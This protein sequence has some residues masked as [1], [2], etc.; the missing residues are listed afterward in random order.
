MRKKF[1]LIF[2]YLFINLCIQAQQTWL[3]AKDA[4]SG[5]LEAG[6]DVAV[7][8]LGNAY[9]GG[10]FRDDISAAYGSSFSTRY[11]GQD[12]FVAKYSSTG[13]LIWAFKLGS[14]GTDDVTGIAADAAGNFYITGS[15]QNVAQFKGVATSASIS[16]TSA[17]GTDAFLAKYNSLGELQW[18]KQGTNNNN[19]YAYKVSLHSSKIFVSGYF[20]GNANFSFAGSNSLTSVGGFDA[21]FSVHDLSGNCLMIKKVGGTAHDYGH[22]ITA[23]DNN[24][25]SIGT[26]FSTSVSFY[27]DNTIIDST[28]TNLSSGES[29]VFYSAYSLATGNLL[30]EERIG[31][32]SGSFDDEGLGI[33]QSGNYIYLTGGA[34]PSTI[35]PGV[36][37]ISGTIGES[38]FLSQALKSNGQ[39]LWAKIESDG[40]SSTPGHGYDI[41]IKNDKIW[42]CG[43]FYSTTNFSG[44]SIISGG[45]EDIFVASYKTDGTLRYVKRAGESGADKAYGLA[46]HGGGSVYISGLVGG[47]AVFDA[48]TFNATNGQNIGVA[49][50]GCNNGG[51]TI[52]GT[53][54][55]TSGQSA[56]LTFNFSGTSPFDYTYSDGTSNYSGSTSSSSVTVSV[57]PAATTTYSLVA[58]TSGTYCDALQSNLTGSAVI[59]VNQVINN[60]VIAANQTI[61]PGQMPSSLTGTLPSGGSGFY[62]YVWQ[63]STDS[64]SWITATGLNGL[65]N[66]SP[67]FLSNKTY[68]RRVVSAGSVTSISNVV[69]ISM[70]VISNNSIASSQSLCIGQIP[71]QLTGTF[72]SGGTGTFSYSWEQSQDNSLWLPGLGTNTSQNYSPPALSVVTYYRRIVSSGTCASNTSNIVVIT[73]PDAIAN[74]IISSNQSICSGQT[75]SLLNGTTPTGGNTAY[76]YLWQQSADSLV[77]SNASGINNLINYNPGAPAAIL[78]FRRQVS[79]GPCA[80]S[81]SNAVKINVLPLITNNNISADQTICSGQTPALLNGTLPGGGNFS[82]SYSWE[83]SADSIT[84]TAAPGSNTVQ[85]YI[86]AALTSTTY[87]KRK[88]NSGSCASESNI[89]K[90]IVLPLVSN[91]II[92]SGQTICSGQTPA[93]LNGSTPTGGNMAY[94]YLWEQSSDNVVWTSATGTNNSQN[95]SPAPLSATT[96]Y[97]RTVSSAMCSS[98]ISNTITIT[99]F[100]VI[101][102]NIVTASQIICSGQTPSVLNGSLPSGGNGSY[103]YLWEQSTDSSTWVNASGINNIQNYS[104]SSLGVTTYYRRKVSSAMCSSSISVPVTISVLPVI[105]NNLISSNQTICSGQTPAALSGSVPVGGNNAY[106]YLWEQSSDNVSWTN[107]AGVNNNQNYSPGLLSGTVYF[108]RTV[109]SAMCSSNISSVITITV[110]PVITNNT[111]SSDQTICSGQSPVILNGSAAAG[112]NSSYVY[113]WEQSADNLTWTNANA[114]NNLQNYS[115]SPLTA[116]T[117]FRRTVSSAMC[118]SNTSNAITVT[119]LPVVSNNVINAPQTICS[120]QAPSVLNGS[121]PSGGNNTYTYLWEQSTDSLLWADA[122]GINNIQ[123]YSPSSLSTTTYFRRTVSSAMCSSYISNVITITVLP[124]ITNN[125]ISSS[126][127]ICAGQIPASLNGTIPLGGNNTYTYLWEESSDNISWNVAAGINN[128]QNYSPAALTN[129]MYYRRTVSSAMCSSNTSLP[130]TIT[131]LPVITGNAISTDQTVCSGQIP[132]GLNGSLPSGGN[133]SYTYLWEQSS[134]S[135]SWINANGINNVQS[136][137]PSTLSATTYYR[138]TVSSAMCSLSISS[139]VKITVLPVIANNVVSAGQTVCFGQTP[140]ALNGSLPSGGNSSFTYLWEQSNDNISWINADGVNNTQNYSAASLSSTTYYRRKVSS[141]MCSEAISNV[142]TITVLPL[143]S[144]NIISSGQTICAGQSPAALSGTVPSGGNNSYAY[145]W[146]QSTDSIS[147]SAANVINTSQNYS[148]STLSATTYYRRIISSAMCSSDTS[149]MVTIIVLPVVTNNTISVNQTICSGQSPSTI[150]GSVPVG[151][152]NSYTFLWLQSPDNISWTNSAGINNTQN[153]SP[154]GLS[155]TV[156]FKR[157][158]SS[159]MCSAD[160]SD[161]VIITVLPVI[162][163]NII[164]SDQTI[165]FGQTPSGLNGSIPSGGNNSFTYLWEQSNDNTVWLSATGVNNAQNYSPSVLNNTTFFRRIVTSAMCSSDTGNVISITVLPVITNNV[166]SADQ[167]ICSGQSASTLNGSVPSGGNNSYSYLWQQSNDSTVWTNA[168]GVNNAQNYSPSSLISSVYY[169]RII[170]SAMC[171]SDTSNTVTIIVLP[172][173]SNNTVSA[174]QTICAGQTPVVLNGSVPSGGN[175]SFVYL[176]EQSNDNVSWANAAGINN[177]QDYNASSLTFTTYF[178]RT[179]SSAMC[180]SDISNAIT[181]TILPVITN[182][183]VTASQTICSGQIPTFLNGSSP[184]G[185]N[186]TYTYLWQESTDNTSWLSAVGI[187]SSQNYIPTALTDTTYYRRITNSAMCSFDTSL[188]VTITVLP[189]LSNNIIFGDQTICYGQNPSVLNGSLPSGGNNSYVYSWEQS[190]DSIAW[191]P[192]N[193][194][195]NMQNYSP[196]GLTSTMYFRRNITSQ[197]CS[198]LSNTVTITVLPSI[199]NNNISLDQTIC[200]GQTPSPLSGSLPNGGDNTYTYFWQQSSDNVSWSAASGINNTASYIPSSLPNTIYYRRIVNSAMCSSDTSNQIAITVLPVISNNTINAPQT[201]CSG[202][203]PLLLNGSLPTGGNNSYSFLWEQSVDSISWSA[204]TGLNN[205]QDYSPSSLSS[206]VYY[207]RII[208]SA[209]CSADTSGL[210]VITVLPVISNNTINGDQTICSGQTPLVFSGS[211]PA[212]GDNSY[213]YL[214]EQSPDNSSWSVASGLNT[215][216]GYIPAT[217]SSTMYYRRIVISGPCASNI[218]NT[219]T[220]T[221]LP[222]ITNNTIGTDQTICFGQTPVM[223]TGSSPNGGDNIF[224]YLWEQSIDSISWSS[225][226]GINYIQDYTPSSLSSTMYFRRRVSSNVCLSSISAAVVITVVPSVTNN[227]ISGDQTICSGQSPL[228]FTGSVPAGGNNSYNYLWEESPDNNSWSSAA[229]VNNLSDYTSSVLSATTYYRRT[230]TSASCSSISNSITITVLPQISGNSI[231][232]SQVICEGQTPATITGPVP[233]G[234]DNTYTYLWQESNNNI[235]WIPAA[236]TNNIQD[237]NPSALSASTYYRRAVSSNTCSDTSSSTTVTVNNL[238][239]IILSG[240]DSICEGAD[241]NINLNLTGASPWSLTYNDGTNNFTLNNINSPNYSFVVQPAQS[242]VYTPVSLTDNNGCSATVINGT[243]S[244]MVNARPTAN[245]GVDDS[246]CSLTCNLNA[247]PSIG[248]GTWSGSG[249]FGSVNSSNST[250][251]ISAQGEHTLTWTENNN[252]CISSDDVKIIFYEPVTADAGTDQDV[253]FTH[254]AV[255]D[256]MNSP[257]KGT[258]TLVSGNGN[259]VSPSWMNTAVT[260]LTAGENILKWTLR[261]GMCPVTEDETKVTVHEL[262]IPNSFSPNGDNINDRY[263]IRDLEHAK[264]KSIQVFNIWGMEVFSSDNYE[265]NWNGKSKEGVDLVADTYYYIIKVNGKTYSGFIV[266]KRE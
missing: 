195:N 32:P 136:Y 46:I 95:Y 29:D 25:Y 111:I 214:W 176:W 112:G 97:R 190:I 210:I 86:P 21:F 183:F 130:V 131:V 55:I 77:W 105:S 264:S 199:S 244:V 99:V 135:L 168:N 252:G 207:R 87:F 197:N 110:L 62:T 259:I 155:S 76:T 30:W 161:A 79:S 226:S 54:T 34:G 4:V 237:Y 121:L 123:N 254:E 113:L 26:Y 198:D 106:T 115:S 71:N 251:T 80:P 94:V 192:A 20:D 179:V 2:L 152:N 134:D 171:S 163:N 235:A 185:G 58:L 137:S 149:S 223:L 75:A 180:A 162:S 18:V 266:L 52:S 9:V 203:T 217:L 184:G 61:C 194:T 250:V 41:K 233:N 93:L 31:S 127:T 164:S 13:T 243:A 16:L 91:N 36:G 35:F 42:I 103:T 188:V 242:S 148:P 186:N 263:V 109:V 114:I 177:A 144:N 215:T 253:Y 202:Q 104:P 56:N 220:I 7:D 45:A 88:A 153:Y 141:A 173:L 120:G 125:S 219:I 44:T 11:G 64:I 14:S 143:I 142:I 28:Q 169:R 261:N 178:R 122:S 119:V 216:Q 147:W 232:S 221:V 100:P 181:I 116:T 246:I 165:C 27:R 22:D 200:Y 166:I 238:P 51:G 260:D 43:E 49:K 108:R 239:S 224:T 67:G 69:S 90:I 231:S 129:T 38:I 158:V 193:G 126:Q 78:Y 85:N 256:A 37:T 96:Y 227:T 140:A 240:N 222:L 196:S 211:V 84:W 23:D 19:A 8:S 118:S 241:F 151:G 245:A 17:G 236:G 204:A 39:N 3:W 66:Y 212:G 101:N 160:T 102:N 5:S 138:R 206:I 146:E 124:V 258:W 247:I 117:Y 154:S 249:S 98:H 82:F 50:L 234:G 72:P 257:G 24:F 132:A 213:S 157:I 12:G 89:V 59:T 57:S 70:S 92:S 68:Y 48:I 128:T 73:I 40:G 167:T 230:I 172:L 209:M 74:N 189:S 170:M 265:N 248:N 33:T 47:S 65:Q 201:I 175:S 15:F 159:A 205:L 255:L 262:K 107:A 81:F 182:N 225:A 150:N 191:T 133:S 83:Q 218:S 229:G 228:L 145:M 139:A 174:S 60:N 1:Y 187:N 208:S 156:Y 53:T 6:N 10:N 63:Q